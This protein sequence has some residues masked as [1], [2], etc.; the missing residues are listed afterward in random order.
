MSAQYFF[1]FHVLFVFQ[2]GSFFSSDSLI[3]AVKPKPPVKYNGDVLDEDD[4]EEDLVRTEKLFHL[5]VF[6]VVCVCVSVYSICRFSNP[7]FL[8]SEV[9]ASSVN[10][11][12]EEDA[13][14]FFT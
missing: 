11:W 14:L 6:F 2:F 7:S 8:N 9:S 3:V 4:D 10:K 13:F 1:W 12:V 5:A